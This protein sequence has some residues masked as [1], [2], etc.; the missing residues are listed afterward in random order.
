MIK[1]GSRI[2]YRAGRGW[3]VGKV[4]K[5][6]GGK[7]V[8]RTKNGYA[9]SRLV[10]E[11]KGPDGEATDDQIDNVT[12]PPEALKASDEKLSPTVSWPSG[13]DGHEDADYKNEDRDGGHDDDEDGGD[14]DE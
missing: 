10:G 11:L 2:K 8:V 1:K 5:V 9:V 3:G 12:P 4:V 13:D 14:G 7:A 6:E